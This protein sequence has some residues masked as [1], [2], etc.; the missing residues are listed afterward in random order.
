[1]SE[2]KIDKDYSDFKA[3][4]KE[5]MGKLEALVDERFESRDK[6]LEISERN[7]RDW[8]HVSN[9]WR[10]E[11]LDQRTLFTTK[12]ES[13]A[14][15]AEAKAERLSIISAEREERLKNDN[16]ESLARQALETRIIL[17][18][19]LKNERT[20]KTY[21]FNIIWVVSLSAI[22]AIAQII[23]IIILLK[24]LIK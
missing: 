7:L 1:M 12:S 13:K 17:L 6:A 19:K 22:S 14:D 15:F 5:R 2:Y 11:N 21:A 8:Q 3:D 4:M 18:E 10:K 23:T 24:N 16:I 20:G 9:E